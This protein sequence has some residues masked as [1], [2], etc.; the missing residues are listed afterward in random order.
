[1][2][3]TQRIIMAIIITGLA[4]NLLCIWSGVYW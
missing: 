4:S 3:T 1:M 2:T